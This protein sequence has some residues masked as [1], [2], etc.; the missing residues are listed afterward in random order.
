MNYF[1]KLKTVFSSTSERNI[2]RLKHFYSDNNFLLSVIHELMAPH[3]PDETIKNKRVFL[4]P[5]WVLHNRK[6]TDEICMRT[7]D[8]FLLAALEIILQKNPSRILIGDAPIQGCDWDKTVR[9]PLKVAISAL[10]QKYQVPITIKDFRR[11]TFN[12]SS[13]NLVK[14]RNPLSDYVIFDL[15]NESY[16][17]PISHDGRNLFRVVDYDPDRLAES[18]RSGVHKYCITK[19][20]FENDIV[21]SLPKVKTHQKTG[22]TNALKILV[23]VNGD[24]DYLPHHR[25]GGTGS[26]GDCYPGNNILRKWSEIL[27]DQAN[28]NR[29]KSQYKFWTNLSSKLWRLS[30]PAEEYSLDA[31]W[32]GNDTTWRM[33][34]DLNKIA[35][36]G[37]ADGTI[38]NT[39]QREIYSLSDGI[40]GGQGNGPLRPEPLSLG[41]VCFS[42]HSGMTD[43]VMGTL[44]GFDI[45]K[46][47]LLKFASEQSNDKKIDIFLNDKKIGLEEIKKYSIKTNPPPGWVNYLS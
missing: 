19:E 13:N 31:A 26:G 37:K 29:G 40:I 25:R 45:N 21:I 24:K 43:N 9:E 5:N 36:Y 6:E 33:V 42:N 3:L 11:V 27:I 35:E 1:V 18:H 41:V 17:E 38:S 34:L 44:M 4:K 12:P 22:I 2:E 23:G 14:E 39:V 10:S 8:K 46:I 16:L 32:Y 28:R 20:L 47:P 7:D 30:F 15:G